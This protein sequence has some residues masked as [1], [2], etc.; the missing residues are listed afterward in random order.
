MLPQNHF[1]ISGV[2]AVPVA[3]IA[4]PQN[5]G[6]IVGCAVVAGGISAAIDL[7]VVVWIYLKGKVFPALRLFY[8]PLNLFTQFKLF[9][10]TLTE[11]GVLRLAMASHMTIFVLLLVCGYF[12]LPAYFLPT[13]IAV[14]THFLSDIPNMGRMRG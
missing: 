3:A 4:Y 10:K 12:F 6:A 7:D 13:A 9:M 2:L 1:L 11:T 5:Y 14:V 8:N